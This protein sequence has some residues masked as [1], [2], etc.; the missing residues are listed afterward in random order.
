MC[1]FLQGET[2]LHK[3]NTLPLG[4]GYILHLAF[5]FFPV[6]FHSTQVNFMLFHEKKKHVPYVELSGKE[7]LVQFEKSAMKSLW[8]RAMPRSI[9]NEMLI[10]N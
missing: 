7:T 5:S 6:D 1:I 4:R 10:I 2:K 8:T 3:N 9:I